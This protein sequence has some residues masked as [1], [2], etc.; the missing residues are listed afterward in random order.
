VAGR[1]VAAQQLHASLHAVAR[2]AALQGAKRLLGERRPSFR[3]EF[4]VAPTAL[5]GP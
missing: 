3:S 4:T 5:E 2:V 1:V